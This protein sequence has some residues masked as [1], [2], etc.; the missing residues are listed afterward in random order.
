MTEIYVAGN[1]TLRRGDRQWSPN[2]LL[3]SSSFTA[4]AE[5]SALA[6]E[7]EILS[8][9]LLGHH[10]RTERAC[11]ILALASFLAALRKK[12]HVGIYGIHSTWSASAREVKQE[13]P[14][15]K[16]CKEIQESI[17]KDLSGLE[18]DNIPENWYLAWLK[19]LSEVYG[20]ETLFLNNNKKYAVNKILDTVM[21]LKKIQLLY[22]NSEF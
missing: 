22:A 17:S 2:I 1:L 20:F 10:Q 15:E 18:A 9:L 5:G 19:D 7:M 16:L 14:R 4:P 11:P 6:V 21:F 13:K 12:M 3:K 8:K